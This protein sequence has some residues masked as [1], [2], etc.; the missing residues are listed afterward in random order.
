MP[1][2]N[3]SRW[4]ACLCAIVFFG[5]LGA[6]A[7]DAST[8]ETSQAELIA[9]LVKAYPDFLVVS[10]K[11][12]IVLCKDGEEWPFKQFSDGRSFSEKLESSCLMDQMTMRYHAG[13]P[14]P[15]P[16]VNEDPGRIRFEPL[17]KKMYG[18]SEASVRRNLRQVPWPPAGARKTV[19]FTRINGAA[20]ALERVGREIAALPKDVSILAGRPMGTFC[21]RPIARTSRLSMHSFCAA[22]DF[23]LPKALYRYWGWDAGKSRFAAEEDERDVNPPYPNNVIESKD[24]S[25]IVEIFERNGF[26]WGGKWRHYDTMHFEYRPELFMD[27]AQTST[28]NP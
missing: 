1:M 17:F 18:D 2:M 20:D 6:S 10:P 9:R 14:Y 13:W 15:A 25:K 27:S 5:A 3:S 11:A 19:L 4:F 23:G 21:W 12:G 24:L 22:I 28:P 8:V 16:V 7:E 26:I